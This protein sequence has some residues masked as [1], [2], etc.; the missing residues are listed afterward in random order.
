V[1]GGELRLC[2]VATYDLTEERLDVLRDQLDSPVVL[3][4]ELRWPE[5]I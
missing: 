2:G 1:I 5:K 3:N 4:E